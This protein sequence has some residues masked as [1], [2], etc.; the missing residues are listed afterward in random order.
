MRIYFAA[1]A[2]FVCLGSG[3]ARADFSYEQTSKIT[4]GMMASMMKVAG[5]FSKQAREPIVT[6][7]LVKG[8]RMA[9]LTANSAHIIDLSKE[10]ITDINFQKKT[11]SVMTFEQ[12]KQALER[13][14]QQTKDQKT[15][16]GADM[17]FKV[18]VKDTGQTKD[19]NGL[20]THEVILSFEMEGTDRKSGQKGAMTVTSDMWLAKDVAGYDEV[21]NF[22][23]RMAEKLAWSPTG[24]GMMSQP[25]LA[26]GMAQLYKES[27][28][29]NGVPV[30]HITKM[31]AKGD[32]EQQA[33]MA[34]AQQQQQQAPPPS[35]GDAAG[36]AATGA[37]SS[38]LGR[39]GGL[40]GGLG[41]LR[42]KKQQEAPAPAEQQQAP[43]GPPPDASGALM[44]MTTD[45]TS[46]S[47]G[48]VDG[49]KFEVPSGFKQVEPEM[50]KRK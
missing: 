36:T 30:H 48:P 6:H 25:E 21:R 32:P 26:K 3:Y 46:F 9:T 35:A 17:N 28:K 15:Q 38:R 12:M 20:N 37:A 16:E 22:H 7:I 29:L 27:S 1:T 33:K 10:T 40:T 50:L 42:R 4:G 41:G 39:L 23:K 45:L 47:A 19:I 43:A 8:D 14:S 18:D 13:L 44:E 11:Y 34:Q 49:S 24:M 5:A 31:G 2:A